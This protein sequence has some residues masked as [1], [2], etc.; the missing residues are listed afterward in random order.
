MNQVTT[1]LRHQFLFPKAMQENLSPQQGW[2]H[3]CAT[4]EFAEGPCAQNDPVLG[5]MLRC[6]CL[7][8]LN[9][10]WICVL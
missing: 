1:A 8:T 3:G 10:L 4:C 5:L 9:Y 6:C 7:E 2:F